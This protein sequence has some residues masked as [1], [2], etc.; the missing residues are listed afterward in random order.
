M[1]VAISSAG[2]FVDA[3]DSALSMRYGL[4]VGKVSGRSVGMEI[5]LGRFRVRRRVPKRAA[6]SNRVGGRFL[7]PRSAIVAQAR[8]IS[9]GRAA[10]LRRAQLRGFSG[11]FEGGVEDSG[12]GSW[13]SKAFKKAT[14]TK[15]SDALPTIA[16]AAA[17]LI[18]GVGPIVGAAVGAAASAL[19][20]Q[21]VP[22]IAGG[23]VTT[24]Q[25]ANGFPAGG[26][27]GPGAGP[28]PAA[29]SAAMYAGGGAQAGR[30]SD[31]GGGGSLPLLLLGG[32]L[33]LAGRR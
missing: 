30:S 9:P 8:R 7:A 5:G 16:G 12:V 6:G 15:L 26:A 23:M 17:S 11:E 3:G 19:S 25:Q 24:G 28:S 29:Q 1:S 13:F 33:L 21:G 20:K 4:D 27:T 32:A 31:T 14:G 22:N 10:A 18:P 2:E